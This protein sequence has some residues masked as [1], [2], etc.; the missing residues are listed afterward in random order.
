MFR[1]A[2]A[3]GLTW[4]E[5]GKMIFAVLT[6]V[7]LV[8]FIDGLVVLGTF[9]GKQVAVLNLGIGSAIGVIGLVIGFTDALKEV[10]STQSVAAAAAS[11]TFAF[12]YILLAAEIWTG[13]DF[14]ALGWYGLMGGIFMVLM[15]LGYSHVLGTTL[16]ASSQFAVFWYL[17][18]ILFWLFWV[19][20]GLGKTK[21]TKITGYYTILVALFT[22]LYPVIAF[23]NMGRIGW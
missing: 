9:G 4:R 23:I 10:G 11:L 18:A 6:L 8:L 12:V 14:K 19:T 13:T 16:I 5:G 20:F 2:E 15:G 7:A 17:W 1:S 22:G 21:W 3:D